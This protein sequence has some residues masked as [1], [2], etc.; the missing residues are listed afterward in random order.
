MDTEQGTVEQNIK[1]FFLGLPVNIKKD[2]FE[3]LKDDFQEPPKIYSVEEIKNGNFEGCSVKIK[4]CI[5]NGELQNI[6][7]GESAK[8]LQLVINKIL[9]DN[10]GDE[11]I[12]NTISKINKSY[13]SLRLNDET[14]RNPAYVNRGNEQFPYQGPNTGGAIKIICT[15]TAYFEINIE[16]DLKMDDKHLIPGRCFIK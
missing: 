2:L 6:Q 15:L 11:N 16:L 12:N 3:S 8:L 9:D 4:K 7:N 5:I 13:K 10:G 14:V 1:S